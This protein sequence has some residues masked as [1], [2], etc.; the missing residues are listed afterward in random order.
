MASGPGDRW[1]HRASSAKARA[2]VYYET[3]QRVIHSPLPNP[4]WE[5]VG[6]FALPFRRCVRVHTQIPPLYHLA[7]KTHRRY[8]CE[9]RSESK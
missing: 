6:Q 7:P 8:T 5:I 1:L 4:R 9:S 3:S 2:W